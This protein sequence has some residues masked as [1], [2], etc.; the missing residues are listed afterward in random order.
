MK[1]DW[2]EITFNINNGRKLNF[3]QYQKDGAVFV[4]AH[5]G[6]EC[7]YEIDIPAGDF[8]MLWSLYR[9]IKTNNIKNDFINPNGK[10][11]EQQTSNTA[12]HNTEIYYKAKTINGWGSVNSNPEQEKTPEGI[13]EAIDYSNKEAIK[14]DHLPNKYQIIKYTVCSVYDEKGIFVE[15][16]T[17]EQV[18][19]AYPL[20]APKFPYYYVIYEDKKKCTCNLY[21]IHAGTYNPVKAIQMSEHIPGTYV[22]KKVNAFDN[23]NPDK[24]GEIVYRNSK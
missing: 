15:R 1:K 19:E 24:P 21:G 10:K 6:T 17:H 16:S 20:S 18:I 5:T 9:H 4:S 12:G 14:N 23:Y 11:E 7:E 8:V 2:N 22:E 3:T 13:K